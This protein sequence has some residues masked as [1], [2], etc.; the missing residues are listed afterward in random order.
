MAESNEIGQHAPAEKALRI[1]YFQHVPFEGL[2]SI[3]PWIRQRGHRLSATQLFR[4]KEL[5]PLDALDCLLVMGG[6]MG[7]YDTIRYPWLN[8]EKRFIRKAVDAGKILLGICLGAQLIA[9]ALGA[10]VKRNPHPEIGWFP[11]ERT[12]AASETGIGKVMPQTMDAFH[13]HGDTFDHPRG[14][15]L[16]A[17]SRA[18]TNQGFVIENRV[19]G[20][21]FHL[22]TTPESA[23]MLIDNC[24]HELDDSRFVQTENEIMSNRGKFDQINSVMQSIMTV[25]EEQATIINQS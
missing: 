7:V 14:S 15:T 5:P 8:D 20:L 21:Q 2:G 13:W 19:V 22:E 16:L 3:E 6:P 9:D 24:R 10:T 12:A 11:I 23:R 25:L 17:T 18:C 4:G 1:H